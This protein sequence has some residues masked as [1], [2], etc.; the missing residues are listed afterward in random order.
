MQSDVSIHGANKAENFVIVLIL[1]SIALFIKLILSYNVYGTND[2][3]YYSAFSEIIQKFGTFKIY[4]LV[5]IYNHPPLM[6]G[7]LK[8][9]K[10]VETKSH[11]NF[12]FLFRLLPIFADYASIFIIW[13]LLKK[14]KIKNKVLICLVCIINPINFLV[15]G[16]HGNTDPVFIFFILLTIYFAENDNFIFSGLIYG[17]SMCVK[18]VPIILAPALFF[19][20]RDSRKR[21]TFFLSSLVL[22]SIV[23]LPYLLKDFYPVTKNIFLYSSLKGIW[24][25]GHVLVSIVAN[26]NININIRNF[27]YTV[28]KFHIAYG[29]IIFFMLSILLS[30]FFIS[31]KKVNLVEVTFLV[32]CLFLVIT[33]GFGVQYLSWLPLF[34]VIVS[35]KL[36]MIYMLLGGFFLYRVYA[37]WS[38]GLPLYYADSDSIG[39]WI[40]FEKTLD[41]ILW[42]LI[43]L[44][45]TKFLLEKAAPVVLGD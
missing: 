28:F 15:S 36:G 22:P 45:L 7:I 29:I 21:I 39:Q 35:P 23:F 37:Y 24:G 17:V 38:G 9:I 3:S 10:L 5:P 34:A 13:K 20:L 14:Y 32:F 33:P 16:F 12:P 19:Y 1:A 18:I 31:N 11:F 25:L 2:V 42:L 27:T 43:I 4:S 44:M 8:L 26:E 6:S 30:K 40:G 41:I